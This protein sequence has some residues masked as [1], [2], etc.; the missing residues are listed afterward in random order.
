MISNKTIYLKLKLDFIQQ[1]NHFFHST[2]N[3]N[4]KAIGPDFNAEF[5]YWKGSRI[6][7]FSYNEL[8]DGGSAAFNFFHY[9]YD[10]PK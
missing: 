5:G 2:D 8:N 3:K 1:K 10:G 9:N 4:F 6:A 7:L